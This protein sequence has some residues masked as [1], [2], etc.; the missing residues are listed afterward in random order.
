[1]LTLLLILP[2][3]V[4]LA[5]EATAHWLFHNQGM[6]TASHLILRMQKR[7]GWPIR[8]LVALLTLTLTLHLEG[9]F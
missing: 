3:A 2:I 5:Y 6:E 1:M 9:L 8:V 4:F 7:F